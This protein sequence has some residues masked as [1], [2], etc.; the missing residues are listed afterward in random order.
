MAKSAKKTTRPVV[1]TKAPKKK[2]APKIK[3]AAPK[4]KE[5]PPTKTIAPK[6]QE[7]LKVKTTSQPAPYL[8]PKGRLITAEGWKRHMIRAAKK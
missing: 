1:K 6:E 4:K 3:S 8:L 5:V 7:T 2:E